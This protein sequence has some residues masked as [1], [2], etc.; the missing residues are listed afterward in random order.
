MH[1]RFEL[2]ARLVQRV[3]DRRCPLRPDGRE[4]LECFLR[5]QPPVRDYG[6]R[7]RARNARIEHL[8]EELDAE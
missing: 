5:E 7:A 8:L 3:E 6:V 1:Q 4:A 2:Y